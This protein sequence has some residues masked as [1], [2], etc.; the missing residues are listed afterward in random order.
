MNSRAL[1]RS[2]GTIAST[3]DDGID[4]IE[5]AAGV[6]GDDVETACDDHGGDARDRCASSL[7][8]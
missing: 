8:C 5:E 1:R 6:V 7:R 2:R 4:K 3:L